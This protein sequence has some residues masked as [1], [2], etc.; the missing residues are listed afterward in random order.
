MKFQ[1]SI[2]EGGGGESHELLYP[3]FIIIIVIF[4]PILLSRKN[5]DE[6]RLCTSL[7]IKFNHMVTITNQKHAFTSEND[8]FKRKIALTIIK[9]TF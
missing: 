3:Y 1:N 9:Q 5:Y 2:G 4:A 8:T 7:Y 6:K